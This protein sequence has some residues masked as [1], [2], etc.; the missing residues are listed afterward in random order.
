MKAFDAAK[1]GFGTTAH[2]EAWSVPLGYVEGDP[3]NGI[4][5]C[6][7][8]LTAYLPDPSFISYLTEGNP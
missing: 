2:T 5:D 3:E 7:M 8:R 1:K 6:E 4:E